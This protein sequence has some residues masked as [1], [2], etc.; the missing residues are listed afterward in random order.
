[1]FSSLHREEKFYTYEGKSQNGKIKKNKKIGLTKF[2]PKI[3]HYLTNFFLFGHFSDISG[4]I[5]Y[6]FSDAF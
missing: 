4:F 3:Q 6:D 5:P 2:Q 1:M